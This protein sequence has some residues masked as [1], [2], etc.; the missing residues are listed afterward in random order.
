MD[1]VVALLA[2]YR[3]KHNMPLTKLS[4][5]LGI[6]A[7]TLGTWERG[8]HSPSQASIERIRAFLAGSPATSP[9][10]PA[11]KASSATRKINRVAL[12]LD[13]SASMQTIRNAAH[14]AFSRILSE[15]RTNAAT[16]SQQ[17]L[18]DLVTFGSTI[19]HIASGADISGLSLTTYMPNESSTRLLDAIGL[20]IDHLEQYRVSPHDDISY[21]VIVVTD[22]LENASRNFG[23]RT[24]NTLLHRVQATDR[25]TVTVQVPTGAKARFCQDFQVPEGNVVEWDQTVAGV[26][27]ATAF[28]GAGIQK[29]YQARASGQTHLRTFY[30]NLSGVKPAVVRK[31]LVDISNEVRIWQVPKEQEIREFCEGHLRG[32][33]LKGAAFYQLTKL[34]RLVQAD[35]EIL[36]REKGKSEIYAGGDA[37]SVLG[38]PVGVNIHLIPGNHANWDIFIQSKST[39]RKLVRGTSVVYWEA[40]GTPFT[41]NDLVFSSAR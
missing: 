31:A 35:K 40:A 22:G 8:V 21:L 27:Q 24:L 32:P 15:L 26:E 18:V 28:A 19:K 25:W 16:H 33:M 23:S 11:V 1:P 34:E 20:A 5:Q 41:A 36:V 2:E 37:R 6:T 10:V 29:F 9:S 4:V 14:A 38:I 7:E 3:R 30:T 12:V 13:N 39:N 17:T